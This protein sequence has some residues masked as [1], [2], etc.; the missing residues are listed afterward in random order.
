MT[1]KEKTRALM[2]PPVTSSIWRL[3]WILLKKMPE[4]VLSSVEEK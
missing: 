4:R 3:D 2:N 1:M